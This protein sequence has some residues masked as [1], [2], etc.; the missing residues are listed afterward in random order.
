M[1]LENTLITTI[2]VIPRNKL[3]CEYTINEND[4]HAM[5][6]D[7]LRRYLCKLSP[8]IFKEITEAMVT[9]RNFLLI[10]PTNEI[11]ILNKEEISLEEV[12]KRIERVT[13]KAVEKSKRKKMTIDEHLDKIAHQTLGFLNRKSNK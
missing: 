4:R 6:Y 3:Y 11:H 7:D 1:E 10:V 5:R 13:I 12:K 9:F 2:L 8:K